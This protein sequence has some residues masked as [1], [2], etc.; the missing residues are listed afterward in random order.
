L[1]NKN[2]KTNEGSCRG[3]RGPPAK[4]GIYELLKRRPKI[5]DYFFLFVLKSFSDYS[6]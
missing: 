2:K 1:K 6:V 4:E 3:N 5:K